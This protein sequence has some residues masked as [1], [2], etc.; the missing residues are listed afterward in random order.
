MPWPVCDLSPSLSLFL[1]LFSSLPL[2]PSIQTLSSSS[3][4]VWVRP[5]KTWRHIWVSRGTTPHVHHL[6]QGQER[7]RK[8]LSRILPLL[9]GN[10]LPAPRQTQP[11]QLSDPSSPENHKIQPSSCRL[12]QEQYSCWAG[13]WEHWCSIACDTRYLNASQQCCP[14]ELVGRGGGE[15]VW[16]TGP[17]GLS[18]LTKSNR[19]TVSDEAEMANSFIRTW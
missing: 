3:S 13:S 1:S 5:H 10:S 19:F 16:E 14:P 15:Q 7:V 18:C 12:Q 17:T 4:W 2:S 11:P 8:P 6:L 9:R